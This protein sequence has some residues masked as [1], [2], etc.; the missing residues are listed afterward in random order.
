MQT[1]CSINSIID[2]NKA[3]N[4]PSEC[5]NPQDPSG[6]PF[7]MLH[8]QVGEAIILLRNKQH[9]A[10]PWHT[11]HCQHPA[12]KPEKSDPLDRLWFVMLHFLALRFVL[13][14]SKL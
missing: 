7:Y 14:F 12:Q 11:A 5:L 4:Y 10:L 3:V 1:C 6:Y 13:N 2:L 9:E 8:L